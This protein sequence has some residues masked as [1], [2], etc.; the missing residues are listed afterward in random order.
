MQDTD[1]VEIRRH[2]I[3]INE[4]GDVMSTQNRLGGTGVGQIYDAFDDVPAFDAAYTEGS[5]MGSDPALA[6]LGLTAVDGNIWT[7]VGN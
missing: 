6:Q 3:F 7:P 1:I 4:Q 2:N 5:D